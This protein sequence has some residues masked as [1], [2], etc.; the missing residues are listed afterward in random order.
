MILI[1]HSR[2]SIAGLVFQ[3]SVPD[4]CLFWVQTD[5]FIF[6]Q[7]QAIPSRFAHGAIVETRVRYRKR[8][9]FN[10][11]GPF[12][13]WKEVRVA[14]TDN[15]MPKLSTL[16]LE[17]LEREIDYAVIVDARTAVGFNDT[18]VLTP[19]IIS[20]DSRRKFELKIDIILCSTVD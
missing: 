19:I 1:C 7:L 4:S 6:I 15:S 13:D 16:K 8:K 2:I 12:F 9:F 20:R 3:E 10:S 18:L 5:D 17:G 14:N 11:T